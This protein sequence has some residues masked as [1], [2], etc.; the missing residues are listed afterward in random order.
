MSSDRRSDSTGPESGT[1]NGNNRIAGF[2][3]D[4]SPELGNGWEVTSFNSRDPVYLQVVRL[5][6]EKIVTGAL[7]PGRVIPSRR[8]LAALLKI[9]PN[10]AQRAYKEMEDQRLIV[11]EGNSPSRITQELAVLRGIRSELLGGAVEAFV[12]SIRNIDVPLDE[13]LDLIRHKYTEAQANQAAE[14]GARDD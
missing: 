6:K 13:L 9:N 11:T 14:G 3:A 10:T 5:F 7:Q 1:G 12:T 2:G 8:E 4:T